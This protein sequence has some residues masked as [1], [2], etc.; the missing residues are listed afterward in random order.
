MAA[1]GSNEK[2]VFAVLINLALAVNKGGNDLIKCPRHKTKTL[3]TICSTGLTQHQLC[4]EQVV[5]C[6]KAAFLIFLDGHFRVIGKEEIVAIVVSVTLFIHRPIDDHMAVAA[7]AGCIRD[8]VFFSVKGHGDVLAGMIGSLMAQGT[9][10]F[11]AACSGVY[12]HGMAG[13]YARDV[14]TEY[15]VAASRLIEN[16][17]M[18]EQR[19]D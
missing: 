2:G 12:L 17:R 16:I 14:Y 15:G 19:N 6:G 8:G 7:S 11:E 18:F 10:P 9:N 1:G 13:D 5:L 4:G 3:D